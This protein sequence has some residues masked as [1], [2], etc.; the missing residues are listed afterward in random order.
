[1][2]A[3]SAWR[4]AGSYALLALVATWPLTSQIT[5][6]LP[7][8]LGDS[9]LNC[10]V[11]SWGA[12]HVL[13][14][15]HGHLSAFNDYWQPPIFYPAPYALAYSEHLFA[16]AL[17]IAPIYALT[18][19]IVLCYNLLFLSTFVV[20]GVGMYL[21][22]HE[23]TGDRVAAWLGGAFYAFALYRLPQYPHLQVLSSGW[24]PL[25][26]FGFRRFFTTGGLRPLAGG[27]LAWLAQNLSCGYF[28]VY[29]SPVIGVYC[30]YEMCQR[31]RWRSPRMWVV[32]AI[33]GAAVA[34]LTWPFVKP[35][36]MLRALGFPPRQLAEVM[37]YS[38]DVLALGTA[39]PGNH[40]WGWLQTFVRAE[41][42]LFPGLV[43]P[44]LA[45]AGLAARFKT[46]VRSARDIPAVGPAGQAGAVLLLVT[47][48][49]LASFA[50]VVSVTRD[51]AWTIAGV[52]LRLHDPWK[53][54]ALAG[55]CTIALLV[56]SRRLRHVAS[57]VPGSL[58]GFFALLTLG[59]M[60]LA[61]GPVPTLNGE[62]TNLPA[63]YAP[64]YWHVPGFD[65]LRVPARFSMLTAC[66]LAVLA[67]FGARAIA[68]AWSRGILV[69]V[70][71]GVLF[72]IESN[73]APIPLNAQL[74]AEGYGVT[75]D[76]VTTGSAA[77]M[78][79][80]YVA[81][82]P[83]DSVLIEFP[84]GSK[85]WDLQALF[86]Q[87]LHRHPIVNGYSGGFPAWYGPTVKIYQH[88]LDDPETAWRT[89]RESRVSHVIVH[90]GAY[91]PAGAEVMDQWL[92]RHGAI[93]IRIDGP[94][95]FYQL[96][97]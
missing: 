96:P 16:Q 37:R 92:T 30:L 48:V 25:A 80:R 23:L 61:T 21:L 9:L 63:L 75:P 28:L 65:G 70:A 88:I 45:L 81:A 89:L 67:A 66:G 3:E 55:A 74:D 34:A 44:L 41:G 8:D 62:V 59:A 10:W 35:Y 64:L 2:L 12:D 1:M 38:A 47:A 91:R 72:L 17:Q 29:F 43:V 60:W 32:L 13:A 50:L 40:V 69:L 82:L 95:A 68:R 73:G 49:V 20:A 6:A 7:I 27:A 4:A 24:L 33:A 15:L 58:L 85:A 42:E 90:R 76:H 53:A 54:W 84:F 94:D 87:R 71:A 11:L 56:V 93:A 52:I 31:G 78:V 19:N 86:Y 77:P 51:P 22:T 79:Y 83:A 97:S 14:L 26:L 57:G 18:G 39:A 46:M 5:T 36:L